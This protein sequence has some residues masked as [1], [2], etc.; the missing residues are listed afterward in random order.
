MSLTE[1]S[2]Q[3]QGA[4]RIATVAA[5]VVFGLGTCA[6]ALALRMEVSS[7]VVQSEGQSATDKPTRARIDAGVM[8]GNILT[9][10]TPVYPE[11]AKAAKV[12]GS[13][14]LHAIIGTDG[15]MKSLA[16]LSGPEMLQGS[17]ID[18]VRQWTYTPY[19]LNGEPTEVDTKIT[20]NF[21]LDDST[22]EPGSAPN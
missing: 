11:I 20:V 8:E 3:L 2:M 12:S 15:R 7:P 22:P 1:K 9:K 10:V 17:A 4:R 6:S 21:N 5:C 18:A 19:L 16:V 14:V 13:V